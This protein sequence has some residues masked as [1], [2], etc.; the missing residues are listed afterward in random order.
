MYIETRIL[1][2]TNVECFSF[3]EKANPSPQ[4]I[5]LVGLPGTGKST[6]RKERLVPSLK[7]RHRSFA[8]YSTDDYLEEIAVRDGITYSEAFDKRFKEAKKYAQE[9]LDIGISY[10]ADLIFDQTNLSEAKRK[11]IIDKLPHTYARSCVYFEP[12][13]SGQHEAMLDGRKNKVIPKK[14]IEDMRKQYVRP[15][16]AEGYDALAN[17][18]D[19]AIIPATKPPE[20]A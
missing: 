2:L 4:A 11:T 12:Q 9:A 15:Y 7:Y 19:N 14:V 8:I 17:Y 18:W 10:G 6:F 3:T 16:A 5:I 20:A 1:P 13:L